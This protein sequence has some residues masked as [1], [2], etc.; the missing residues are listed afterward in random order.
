MVSG[1]SFDND[2]DDFQREGFVCVRQFLDAQELE[3]LETNWNRY[4]SDVVPGLPPSDAFF[5]E[6]GRPET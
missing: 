2:R 5:E 4:I 6:A 3:E 1:E